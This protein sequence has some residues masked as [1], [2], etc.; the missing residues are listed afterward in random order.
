MIIGKGL[1]SEKE[2]VGLP[3][4]N[5]FDLGRMIERF[6]SATESNDQQSEDSQNVHVELTFISHQVCMMAA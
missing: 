6:K 3:I 5:A 1:G 4:E 2:I